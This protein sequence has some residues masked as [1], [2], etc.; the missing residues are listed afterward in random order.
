MRATIDIASN[1]VAI[2]NDEHSLLDIPKIDV[3]TER[4]LVAQLRQRTERDL[5][6]MWP[7]HR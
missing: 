4:A 5:C 7:V 6:L 3:D 2:Q 1:R